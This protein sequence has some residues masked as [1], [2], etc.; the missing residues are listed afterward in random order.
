MVRREAPEGSPILSRD[1]RAAVAFIRAAPALSPTAG[2]R[3][4]V[5][6]GAA[7]AKAQLASPLTCPDLIPTPV[8]FTADGNQP[9]GRFR[10]RDIGTGAVNAAPWEGPIVA[11]AR[12]P[13]A[14]QPERASHGAATGPRRRQP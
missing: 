7:P 3:A 12:F 13:K 9:K 8:T 10:W 6:A 5:G 1:L 11:P 2:T 4:E 14:P